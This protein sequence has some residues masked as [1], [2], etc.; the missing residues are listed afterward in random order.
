MLDVTFLNFMHRKYWTLILDHCEAPSLIWNF[1]RRFSVPCH[2]NLRFYFPLFLKFWQFFLLLDLFVGQLR[3]TLTCSSC[4]HASVTFDPFWDLS[5]PISSV[6]QVQFYTSEII[7]PKTM[8]LNCVFCIFMK[9]TVDSR[10]YS[11][12]RG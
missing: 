6:S 10:F 3:S 1:H 2:S 8:Y 4:H 11:E 9:Y 5:L 7:D 12:P